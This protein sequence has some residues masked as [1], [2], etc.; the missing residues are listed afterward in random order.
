M[1]SGGAAKSHSAEAAAETIE[2]QRCNRQ[3]LPGEATG[4]EGSRLGTWNKEKGDGESGLLREAMLSLRAQT[5]EAVY[6][7]GAGSFLQPA[8][9]TGFGVACRFL[10]S[11]FVG[12]AERVGEADVGAPRTVADFPDERG[13]TG[14]G[15]SYVF[16]ASV[17]AGQLQIAPKWI[18]VAANAG[19]GRDTR[20]SATQDKACLV[21]TRT[22]S[23]GDWTSHEAA[24]RGMGARSTRGSRPYSSNA[25]MRGISLSG[26]RH[27]R[28][29]TLIRGS[30]ELC[31]K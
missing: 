27:F 7:I 15:A 13:N 8:A 14:C 29:A 5:H 4:K 26:C 10:F 9:R 28:E 31:G 24:D 20:A 21:C 30:D 25:R 2:P 11:R 23:P 18:S 1:V 19:S 22:F 12:K 6:L 3:G 16:S 17:P